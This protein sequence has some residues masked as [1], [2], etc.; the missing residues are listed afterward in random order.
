[1]E[2]EPSAA[3]DAHSC[4]CQTAAL[5]RLF[6]DPLI[7]LIN[8]FPWHAEWFFPYYFA[9][10]KQLPV[11]PGLVFPPAVSA[12]AGLTLCLI[13]SPVPQQVTVTSAASERCWVLPASSSE[14]QLCCSNI[15]CYDNEPVQSAQIEGSGGLSPSEKYIHNNINFCHPVYSVASSSIN[16][17]T[18]N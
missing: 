2:R 12:C 6:L 18:L 17:E 4:P 3:R 9:F 5:Q 16:T 11:W 7:I 13:S 1:M 14:V 15:C 10:F 8:F